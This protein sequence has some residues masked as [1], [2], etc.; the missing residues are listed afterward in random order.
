MPEIGDEAVEPI[1]LPANDLE[2]PA[3]IL[4][5]AFIASKQFDRP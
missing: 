4:V 3:F 1:C 2:E 5:M